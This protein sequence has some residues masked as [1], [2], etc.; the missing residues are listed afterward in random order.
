MPF[1]DSNSRFLVHTCTCT[2]DEHPQFDA[3][4]LML[5]VKPNDRNWGKSESTVDKWISRVLMPSWHCFESEMT[6][7][8]REYTCFFLYCGWEGKQEISDI[9][10][11]TCMR[12]LSFTRLNLICFLIKVEIIVCSNVTPFMT[13]NHSRWGWWFEGWHHLIVLL[14]LMQCLVCLL[15]QQAFE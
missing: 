2:A 13:V 9:N 7:L 8:E 11:S 12:C 15:L 10:L 4:L 6:W 14:A 3:G 1:T 5:C